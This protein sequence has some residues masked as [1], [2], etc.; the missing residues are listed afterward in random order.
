MAVT[1]FLFENCPQDLS[2]QKLFPHLLFRTVFLCQLS[3]QVSEWVHACVHVCAFCCIVCVHVFCFIVYSVVVFC[4]VCSVV[5]W[6]GVCVWVC[7]HASFSQCRCLHVCLYVSVRM[8]HCL[9]VSSIIVKRPAHAQDGVPNKSPLLPWL[10][11]SS[12]PLLTAWSPCHHE[13]LS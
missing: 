11:W 3:G 5:V 7:M 13:K 6:C 2:V 4:V 9:C 8:Q 10:P 1:C 12:F